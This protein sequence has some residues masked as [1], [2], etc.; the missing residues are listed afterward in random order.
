M[1][2]R[3][4]ATIFFGGSVADWTCITFCLESFSNHAQPRSR[5]VCCVAVMMVPL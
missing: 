1:I 5:L 2:A 4:P 3:S